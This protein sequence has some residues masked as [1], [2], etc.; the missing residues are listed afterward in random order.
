[1]VMETARRGKAVSNDIS[2]SSSIRQRPLRLERGTDSMRTIRADARSEEAAEA[3]EDVTVPGREGR[4]ALESDG[5]S[6]SLKVR[7]P[8]WRY[9]FLAPV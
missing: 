4:L 2:S 7:V 8:L 5:G 9:F 6:R 3:T 1:M